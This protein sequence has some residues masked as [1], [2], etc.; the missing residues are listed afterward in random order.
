MFYFERD[1]RFHIFFY[2]ERTEQVLM[3]QEPWFFQLVWIEVL[4][5][6]SKHICSKML[7]HWVA[8]VHLPTCRAPLECARIF[9]KER[10]THRDRTV[11]AEPD[12]QQP[13]PL[14]LRRFEFCFRFYDICPY[15]S[16]YDFSWHDDMRWF[17]RNGVKCD[18]SLELWMN[19]KSNDFVCKKL[20]NEDY[21]GKLQ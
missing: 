16:S 9:I 11:F 13:P 4:C 3:Q 20:K 6:V 1:C 19:R 8:G 17:D 14:L 21:L 12:W 10:A 5:C 2:P 7:M 18:L 15:V